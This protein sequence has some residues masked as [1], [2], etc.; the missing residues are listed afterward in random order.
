MW[1]LDVQIQSS[2]GLLDCERVLDSPHNWKIHKISG[3]RPHLKTR[4]QIQ[5]F[6]DLLD[7]RLTNSNHLSMYTL[8]SI[9]IR[10]YVWTSIDFSKHLFYFI[11]FL[12]FFLHQV[13]RTVVVLGQNLS[14]EGVRTHQGYLEYDISLECIRGQQCMLVYTHTQL[15]LIAT[16]APFRFTWWFYG[17]RLSRKSRETCTICMNFLEQFIQNT[18]NLLLNIK[19]HC[20]V[21]SVL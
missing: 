6:S 10:E 17:T 9:E 4:F 12:I 3:D 2:E 16:M 8:F 18:E 19:I 15:T 21:K 5:I 13:Q 14:L 1:C 11:L 20:T 7:P